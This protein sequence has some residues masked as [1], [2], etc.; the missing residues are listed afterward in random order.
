MIFRGKP[1]GPPNGQDCSPRSGRTSLSTGVCC[2]AIVGPWALRPARK[3]RGSSVTDHKPGA[4]LNLDLVD[5]QAPGDCTEHGIDGSIA[6]RRRQHVK[7]EGER[8]EEPFRGLTLSAPQR[9]CMRGKHR[10]AARVPPGSGGAFEGGRVVP[11]QLSRGGGE[12]AWIRDHVRS[13]IDHRIAS[14]VL[15]FADLP[16]FVT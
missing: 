14:C 15:P 1:S 4:S 10:P 9:P 11:F 3:R 2:W 6:S 16:D 8:P 7:I 13:R 5:H 12:E